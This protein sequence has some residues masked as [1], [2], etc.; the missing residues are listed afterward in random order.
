MNMEIKVLGAGCPNCK[1]LYSE[2]ERAI[3][4]LGLSAKLEKV[5]DI[6]DIMAYQIMAMP[7]LVVNGVV[8]AAGRVPDAAEIANWIAAAVKE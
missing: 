8:K 2:A 7:A 4:Q 5:E 6:T 3:G 1:R